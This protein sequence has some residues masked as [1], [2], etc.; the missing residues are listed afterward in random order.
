LESIVQ[1]QPFRVLVD[2]AFEPV[3]LGKL[4]ETIRLLKPGKVIHVLGSAGGGRDVARRPKLGAVAGEQA[5]FVIITDEDPY[6]DDPLIIMDQVSLGAEKAGKKPGENLWKIESRRDAIRKALSLASAGDMVL[7][8]GKGSEQ[9]ICRADGEKE[10]WDDRQV[11]REELA[12]LGYK[13]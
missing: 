6:D 10:P 2:Y 9:G 8:T 11:V 12:G 5:D 1:G 4:Y 13:P 3:A 7:V